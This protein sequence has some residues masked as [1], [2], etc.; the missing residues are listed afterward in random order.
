MMGVH[1]CKA[2]ADFLEK[3]GL[4]HYYEW[5]TDDYFDKYMRDMVKMKDHSYV[6]GFFFFIIIRIKNFK[7]F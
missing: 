5:D 1:K 7:A 2:I 3:S 6:T 4:Y